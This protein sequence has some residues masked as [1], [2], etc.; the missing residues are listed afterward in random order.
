MRARLL[1]AA[2]GPMVTSN[3]DIHERQTDSGLT[4]VPLPPRMLRTE[5]DTF[6][7]LFKLTRGRPGWQTVALKDAVRAA[8][9]RTKLYHRGVTWAQ[10]AAVRD[11]WSNSIKR[12]VDPHVGDQF[13]PMSWAQFDAAVVTLRHSMRA[14]FPTIFH[15]ERTFRVAHAQKSLSLLLKHSWCHGQAAEPPYCP[16][17]RRVLTAAAAPVALRTWSYIDTTV[18]YHGRIAML[19]AAAERSPW[20]PI[21][22]AEWELVTFNHP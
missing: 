17:D 2:F 21:S 16:V 7:G 1:L 9:V 18:D 10:R 5:Q 14:R 11:H 3:P 8:S 13:R 20:A 6:L 4:L 22:A 19:V 12:I 15:D